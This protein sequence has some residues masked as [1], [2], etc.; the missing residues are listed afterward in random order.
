LR[1]AAVSFLLSDDARLV[2]GVVLPV[3]GG[4]SALGVDPEASDNDPRQQGDVAAPPWAP[5]G[6]TSRAG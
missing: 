2:T 5:L 4:R 1:H 3:H 6:G